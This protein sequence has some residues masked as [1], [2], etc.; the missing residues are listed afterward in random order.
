MYQYVHLH[1]NTSFMNNVQ[2]YITLA[3]IL[4]FLYLIWSYFITQYMYQYVHVRH[5]FYGQSTNVQHWLT[6][7]YAVVYKQQYIKLSYTCNHSGIDLYKISI[8]N[9]CSHVCFK[10]YYIRQE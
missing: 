4:E 10:G 6:L 9:H 2:M 5:S 8:N 7:H 1:G 3:L